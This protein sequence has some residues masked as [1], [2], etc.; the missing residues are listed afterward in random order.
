MLAFVLFN[1]GPRGSERSRVGV[2]VLVVLVLVLVLIQ[3]VLVLIVLVLVLV[4]V[5]CRFGKL[6]AR[7][8]T[9]SLSS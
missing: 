3:V 9:I 6:L 1:Q 4:L 2:L 5:V 7:G 8:V